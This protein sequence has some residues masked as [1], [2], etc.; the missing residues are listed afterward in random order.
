M[1]DAA[2]VIA[3]VFGA[4]LV[5]C[6]ILALLYVRPLT[7]VLSGIVVSSIGCGTDLLQGAIRGVWPASA[8][9]WLVRW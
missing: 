9:V 3:F 4:I 2:R 8:L 1:P 7:L 6:G 5:V